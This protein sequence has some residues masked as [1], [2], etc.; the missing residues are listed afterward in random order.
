[1]KGK[2]VFVAAL[3]AFM[4]LIT[5]PASADFTVVYPDDTLGIEMNL[6]L[7][8]HAAVFWDV[9]G[10]F[11]I[12]TFHANQ[13]GNPL[14]A[15]LGGLPSGIAYWLNFVGTDQFG[16]FVFDVFVKTS[17]GGGFFLLT[18]IAF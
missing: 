6:G 1:M 16:R 7:G 15:S 4:F 10:D 11:D 5:R 3:I 14:F 17:L 18:T 2:V 8:I 13:V 12:F 9:P